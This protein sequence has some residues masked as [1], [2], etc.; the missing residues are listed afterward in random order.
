MS[1]GTNFLTPGSPF[2]SPLKKREIPSTSRTNEP[3]GLQATSP[4]EGSYFFGQKCVVFEDKKDKRGPFV[5]AIANGAEPCVY[6]VYAK[7][8]PKI[9]LVSERDRDWARGNIE[10]SHIVNE[11]GQREFLYSGAAPIRKTAQGEEID[12]FSGG[13]TVP[14]PVKTRVLANDSDSSHSG[15]F[16]EIRPLL[17]ILRIER[18]E[19]SF[20]NLSEIGDD[21]DINQS[22]RSSVEFSSILDITFNSWEGEHLKLQS[23]SR[24]D[25]EQ[26]YER[27]PEQQDDGKRLNL[28][29]SMVFMGR[30]GEQD[31]SLRIK[32][33]QSTRIGNPGK[34][35]QPQF[36][37]PKIHSDHQLALKK[38]ANSKAQDAMQALSQTLTDMCVSEAAINRYVRNFLTDTP[39]MVA[40]NKA[41]FE[42]PEMVLILLGS[43]EFGVVVDRMSGSFD[44]NQKALLQRFEDFQAL[45]NDQKITRLADAHTFLAKDISDFTE[46]KEELDAY[47]KK[48][49]QQKIASPAEPVS[50]HK[51]RKTNNWSLG[52]SLP[53]GVPHSKIHILGH[54]LEAPEGSNALI[55][56]NPPT[57][58]TTYGGG[59]QFASI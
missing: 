19:D 21:G 45:P 46:A 54:P 32:V 53:F 8:N 47:N 14:V 25:S 16:V 13:Q 39:E 57:T 12:L 41:R 27:K 40:Y 1:Y 5:L 58:L 28:S 4:I 31:N 22:R 30:N 6:K 55:F 15:K 50:P 43:H 18:R 26:S 29:D 7:S 52:F 49:E 17:D 48:T 35:S 10:R 37:G 9:T 20:G 56:N 11:Q 42:T 2:S 59:G 38:D 3:V 33:K 23:R 24:S 36:Q 44:T 34:S 51:S